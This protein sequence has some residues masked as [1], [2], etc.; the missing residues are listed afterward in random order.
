MS[1]I[2]EGKLAEL[3]QRANH[4]RQEIVKMVA[5]ANSG[6]PGG[7][8]SAADILA[9]LY[10]HEMNVG[11][12]KVNDPDRDRFILSKGHASPVLYATLAEKGYLS[13]E[14]LATFR[15]INSRLQGHPSKK[16]L[17]GV[18]QSTGSLG[19][20]LSTANGMALAARLDKREYR[21]YAL[22][23]DGEIQEGMIWEAAMAAGHYKL[24]NLVA[25]L[26]YN[27]L[28]IDGNVEDIMDIG[29][30]AD[31]FRAFNWHVIEMDGHNIEEIVAA[32]AEARTVKGKPTFIVA[33]T[34]KGKG[35]SYMENA[36]GWHGVA[37][38]E[39]QLKQALAELCAQGGDK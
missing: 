6:H 20:G 5:A 30:V 14:E 26:D 32:F 29:P 28:Q 22:L 2:A 24:D 18:E 3:K 13:K 10:F 17:P 16:L 33:H 34:I 37:P 36:C 4:I 19:Q 38:N 35:V 39:E 25:I 21:V 31:K 12:E 15:R 9:V 23:G 1:T 27:H 8:L 11:P 7:S